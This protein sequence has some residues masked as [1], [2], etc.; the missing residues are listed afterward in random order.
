MIRI[1]T[2]DDEL[3]KTAGFYWDRKNG[4]GETKIFDGNLTVQSYLAPNGTA[5]KLTKTTFQIN[6]NLLFGSNLDEVRLEGV[7]SLSLQ[8]DGNLTVAKD[9]IGSSV[10]TLSHLT[11]G[12][13]VDGYDSY[14][15]DD[16]DKGSRLGQGSLGGFSGGQGPGKGISLGSTGAGGLT[17]GGGSYAGEG[18][19]GASAPGGIR[20][21]SGGLDVLMGG[22][23]GGPGNGGEAGAGGGALELIISGKH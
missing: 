3:G 6:G 12:T 18:G 23:G 17:G 5:W 15:A 13:L 21:G 22:S 19:G 2:G 14:Y 10:P 20:Y 16:P 1:N 11:G 7:N 8:V 9:L 4:E